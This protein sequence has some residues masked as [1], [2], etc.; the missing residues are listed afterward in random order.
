MVSPDLLLL[1]NSDDKPGGT[2]YWNT[3]KVYLDNEMNATQ[4]AD[5]LFI[6]RTTLRMRLNRIKKVVDLSTPLSRMYVRYCLYLYEMFDP[7]DE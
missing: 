4:T 3:L 1:K 5:D 7:L 2:D 6:H